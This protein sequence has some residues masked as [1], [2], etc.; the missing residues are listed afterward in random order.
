MT[1]LA[2]RF[3]DIINEHGPDAVAFYGSGQL[4][5]E[6][7]YIANKLVK[8]FIGTNNFDTNS[9]LVHGFG[10]GRLQKLF[11]RRWPA[12]L[13]RRYRRGQLYFPDR[14]QHRGLPSGDF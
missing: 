3:R 7:Y 1:Y 14:H 5:T 8:G 9:R 11:W 13:L 4:T 6:E 2:K 12:Q 10:G